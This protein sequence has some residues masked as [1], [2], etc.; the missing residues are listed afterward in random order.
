MAHNED[1]LNNLILEVQKEEAARECYQPIRLVTSR[2]EVG[3]RFYATPTATRCGA[4]W[5]GGAGGG[6]DTPARGLYPRLCEELIDEGVASLRVRFRNPRML[7]KAAFDVRAGLAYLQDKGI[8]TVALTGHSL[9]GAA[10]IQAA[11]AA[12]N[13]RTVVALATQS[14]GADPAARLGPRCSILLLHGT[15]DQVLPA[16]CSQHVHDIARKPKRLVR[17]PGAGHVLNEAADDVYREVRSWIVTQLNAP[18]G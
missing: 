4:I 6:W 14:Y 18:T 11:A 13:A 7:A 5:V 1:A 17:C 9:G 10:V 8:D 2:G 12:P 16:R 15:A 3:C